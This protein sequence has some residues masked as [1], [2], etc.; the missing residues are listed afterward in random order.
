MQTRKET[1]KKY[2]QRKREKLQLISLHEK[3]NEFLSLYPT[4]DTLKLAIKPNHR[5]LLEKLHGLIPVYYNLQDI[6]DERGVSRQA[7]HRCHKR[8]LNAL[9]KVKCK[10]N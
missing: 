6:A 7:V 9:E 1:Q 3:K 4:W 5:E 8:A 10:E 2:Y